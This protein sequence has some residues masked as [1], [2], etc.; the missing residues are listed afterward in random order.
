[1]NDN[2]LMLFDDSPI[3]IEVWDNFVVD[4]PASNHPCDNID[5][6]TMVMV[7]NLVGAQLEL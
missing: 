5:V 1:M 6:Q 7:A 4:V 3:V 2:I